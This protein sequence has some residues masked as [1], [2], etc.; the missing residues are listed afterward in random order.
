M[1]RFICELDEKAQ[2][3]IKNR[4]ENLK[5]TFG[6]ITTED[7]ER[8]LEEKINIVI[9][10]IEWQEWSHFDY[11]LRAYIDDEAV[12]QEFLRLFNEYQKQRRKQFDYD[13]LRED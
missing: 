3:D 12:V 13:Y 9:P 6:A 8:A 5:Q 7:I 1:P 4:L 2:L 10:E 11:E